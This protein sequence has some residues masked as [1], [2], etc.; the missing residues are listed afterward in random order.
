MRLQYRGTFIHT[1]PGDTA[2]R[3]QKL[4]N[5]KGCKGSSGAL[6]DGVLAAYDVHSKSHMPTFLR[7]PHRTHAKKVSACDL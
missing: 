1:D 4:G 7:K 6:E 2:K 3:S 5:K